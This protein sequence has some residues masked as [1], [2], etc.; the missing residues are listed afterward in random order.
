MKTKQF[1]FCKVTNLFCNLTKSRIMKTGWLC[2]NRKSE[3]RLKTIPAVSRSPFDNRSVVRSFF[4][5]IF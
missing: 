2:W 3:N 1:M 4:G 5:E